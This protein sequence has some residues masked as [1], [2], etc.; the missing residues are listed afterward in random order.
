MGNCEVEVKCFEY[1]FKRYGRVIVTGQQI[2][3]RCE[4]SHLFE[5]ATC[6]MLQ[7]AANLWA[8]TVS[9]VQVSGRLRTARLGTWILLL[10][11]AVRLRNTD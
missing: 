11:P 9:T 1:D 3:R 2:S 4:T 6:S 8:H 5:F 10:V 7:I